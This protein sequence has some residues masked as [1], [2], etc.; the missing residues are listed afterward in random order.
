VRIVAA[1]GSDAYGR[2]AVIAQATA[3]ARLVMEVSPRSFT[4]PPKVT[5]AV[6]HLVPHAQRLDQALLES[7]QT[8]TAAAFGQRR[9]MLRSS[10]KQLGGET[11]CE[12]AGI[13]P[14]RR[15]ETLDVEEFLKLA[16]AR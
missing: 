6:V 2:L 5:S 1:P 4:P 11:I 15:A 10:L 7:L 12:A 13:D 14:S 3:D 8:L 16:R 9:K